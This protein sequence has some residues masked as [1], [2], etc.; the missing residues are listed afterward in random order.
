[1]LRSVNG[2][3][4][5]VIVMVSLFIKNMVVIEK[6]KQVEVLE[7][8]DNKM[9]LNLCVVRCGETAIYRLK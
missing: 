9:K 4:V 1:M 6:N 5:I 7:V 2:I 3:R 8:M